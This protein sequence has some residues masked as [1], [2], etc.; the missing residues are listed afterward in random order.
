MFVFDKDKF[1]KFIDSKEFL[2]DSYTAFKNKIGLT[3]DDGKYISRS[4]EVVWPGLLRIVSWR[5]DRRKPMRKGRR[6][7]NEILAPDEIDRLLEPKVFSNIKRIDKDGNMKL[8]KLSQTTILLLKA[9]TF[10]FSIH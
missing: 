6:F 8:P 2:P 3:T 10:W 9:T 5:A 4:R 1:I 7:Y